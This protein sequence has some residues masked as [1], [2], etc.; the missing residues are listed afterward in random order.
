MDEQTGVG[1]GGVLVKLEYPPLRS[2]VLDAV[3]TDDTGAFSFR[4]APRQI[5]ED[6]PERITRWAKYK[7]KLAR[8]GGILQPSIGELT[9]GITSHLTI[10]WIPNRP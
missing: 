8:D 2:S 1:L 6:W 10:Q 9:P 4:N 3:L 5:P 7:V